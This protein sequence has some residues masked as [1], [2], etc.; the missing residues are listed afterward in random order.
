M[1]LDASK[2]DEDLMSA[3]GGGDSGAFD[4]LY[5]R[6]KGGVYRYLLRR[7][8][9]DRPNQVWVDEKTPAPLITF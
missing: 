7:L 5:K 9:I 6:H 1:P 2:S 4:E 3:Y 8:V